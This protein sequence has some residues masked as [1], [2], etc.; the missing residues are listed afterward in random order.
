MRGQ[1]AAS[2]DPARLDRFVVS[3]GP[4]PKTS[5]DLAQGTAVLAGDELRRR[6]D[7][8]ARYIPLERLAISPQC[9]FASVARGNL[10]SADDQW[11]KLALVARTARAVWG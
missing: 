11:R 7:E 5:F 1:G 4:D 2:A 6:L 3:A 10:L 9:G 8:A